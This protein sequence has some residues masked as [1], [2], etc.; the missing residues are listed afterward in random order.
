MMESLFRCR[1]CDR[2]WK[3]LWDDT[4]LWEYAASNDAE[5]LAAETPGTRALIEQP[6]VLRE[7]D[8]AAAFALCLEAAE[9]GSGSAMHSTGVHYHNGTSVEPDPE[10]AQ[11]YYRRAV[12]AGSWLA[13]VHYARFLAEHGFHDECETVLK[14][15]V[16]AKFVPSYFWLA[17]L[18]SS[19]L[20]TR[21]AYREARPLLEYAAAQG[22]PAAQ[23]FRAHFLVLGKLGIRN[24]PA[25]IVAVF[26]WAYRSARRDPE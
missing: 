22:H 10:R 25:G 4:T 8:D 3:R 18:R 2:W 14:D 5:L 12:E 7:A 11:E 6:E 13:T 15:G 21:S 26:R 20:Q 23:V 1:L 16:A 17:Y 19:R 9:A 24:I